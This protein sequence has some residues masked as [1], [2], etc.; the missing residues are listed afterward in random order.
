[1]IS[2]ASQLSLAD[3]ANATT[4]ISWAQQTINAVINNPTALE[5]NGVL[6]EPCDLV[7]SCSDN[8]NAVSPAFNNSLSFLIL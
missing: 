8:D 7:N 2:A 3:P 1:M 6:T 4:Y 5:H